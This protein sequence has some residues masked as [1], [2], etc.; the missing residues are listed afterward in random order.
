M[1]F[2]SLPHELQ[3]LAALVRKVAEERIAPLVGELERSRAFAAPVRQILAEAGFLGIVVPAEY[4]GV[5]ADVRHEVIVMEEVSKVYPSAS[6]IL[7]AHWVPT[8]L[9]LRAAQSGY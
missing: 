1:L 5:D 8:K 4:G 2:D 6:T 9:I 3:D 7:T